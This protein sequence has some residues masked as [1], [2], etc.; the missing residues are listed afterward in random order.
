[1]SESDRPATI[2]EFI[3]FCQGGAF[4][5]ELEPSA[6]EILLKFT[7]FRR[8]GTDQEFTEQHR[9]IL[10][11]ARFVLDPAENTAP[12]LDPAR[13]FGTPNPLG[14]IGDI[15]DVRTWE[16]VAHLYCEVQSAIPLLFRY[17]TLRPGP[18]PISNLSMRELTWITDDQA[19]PLE[20]R[21][22]DLGI[23]PSRMF[24]FT[25]DHLALLRSVCWRWDEWSLPVIE[26]SKIWPVI[27]VDSKRTYWTSRLQENFGWPLD[28]DQH[29]AH[30]LTKEQRSLLWRTHRQLLPAFQVFVENATLAPGTYKVDWWD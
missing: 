13:P 10:Q 25:S 5:P 22:Q 27:F 11:R 28:P 7:P 20:V 16:G 18:Y 17:G 6:R 2:T 23:G 1:M 4:A 30:T 29:G 15:T 21:L 19:K 24:D 26:D 8:N 14:Q 12:A 9:A 3:A